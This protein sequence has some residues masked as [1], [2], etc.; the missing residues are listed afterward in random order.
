MDLN[1]STKS[2]KNII[3]SLKIISELEIKPLKL[4]KE[5]I[6]APDENTIREKRIEE[7]V[8]FL[9]KITDENLS[10]E[11]IQKLYERKEFIEN[12][13]IT[14]YKSNVT[15]LNRENSL[16]L[17]R[18]LQKTEDDLSLNNSLEEF[19][20][21]NLKLDITPL[22]ENEIDLIKKIVLEENINL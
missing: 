3:K 10:K 21:V 5:V 1:T 2:T 14:F 13:L 20:K 19:M 7:C 6:I 18:E 17:L 12:N 8:K 15:K 4:A 11:N 16:K 22:K 9:L